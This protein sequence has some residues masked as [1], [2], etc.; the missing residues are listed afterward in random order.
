M[1]PTLWYSVPDILVGL[2]PTCGSLSPLSVELLIRAGSEYRVSVGF[3]CVWTGEKAR[4]QI[5]I[6]NTVGRRNHG[7]KAVQNESW[8]EM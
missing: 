7:R 2:T 8:E 6:G 4:S 1:P 3:A 5:E